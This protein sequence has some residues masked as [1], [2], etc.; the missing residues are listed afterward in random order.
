[1][2][3]GP[4]TA[5][6]V[7]D[8]R[9]SISLWSPEAESL[10]GYRARDICG[11]PAVDLLITPAD[12][13]AAL[14]AGRRWGGAGQGWDG[15]LAM[16][17]RDG[18]VVRVALCVRPVLDGHG[19]AGWSVGAADVRQVERS[20]FDQAV[21]KALFEQAPVSIT[22]VG[23]DLKFRA[24]N[25]V[26]IRD[27]SLPAERIIGRRNYEVAPEIDFQTAEERL[28]RVRDTGEPEIGF[29]Y[30]VDSRRTRSARACGPPHRSG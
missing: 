10:L 17:H 11:T 1:M 27:L 19:Q 7:V 22:V 12:R 29:R 6:A 18:H 2:L 14:A 26:A 4:S 30:A 8:G 5:T 20:E 23:T 16:R 13:E 3:Q 25:A 9:G 21:L 28:R 15:V 24:V